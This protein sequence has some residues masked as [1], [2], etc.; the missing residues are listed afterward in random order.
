MSFDKHGQAA[1]LAGFISKMGLATGPLI[2]SLFII[3]YGFKFIINI[4]V[5]ALFIAMI[6]S[7]IQV[8]LEKKKL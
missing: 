6:M 3:E 4:A 2:G 7:Y 5:F 8:K 1:A